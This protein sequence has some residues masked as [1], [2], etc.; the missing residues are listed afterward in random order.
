MFMFWAANFPQS[1]DYETTE[2]WI[3]KVRRGVK[4]VLE[5]DKRPIDIV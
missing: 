1:A 3:M 2:S 5:K 4:G